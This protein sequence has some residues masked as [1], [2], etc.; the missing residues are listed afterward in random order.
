MGLYLVNK[1][2]NVVT[3]HLVEA[4]GWEHLSY[5]IAMDADVLVYDRV[6]SLFNAYIWFILKFSLPA[7]F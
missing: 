5:A 3:D 4:D 7:M 2:P 6:L 1:L